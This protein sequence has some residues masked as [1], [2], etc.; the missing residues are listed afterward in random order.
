[1]PFAQFNWFL[2]IVTTQ[3]LVKEKENSTSETYFAPVDVKIRWHLIICFLATPH[4]WWFFSFLDNSQIV[5]HF[6]IYSIKYLFVFLFICTGRCRKH[7][8]QQY[9]FL[10]TWNHCSYPRID[11]LRRKITTNMANKICKIAIVKNKEID[12]TSRW[13]LIICLL[14]LGQAWKKMQL[15]MATM[16]LLFLINILHKA[17]HDKFGKDNEQGWLG[18]DIPVGVLWN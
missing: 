2:L 8:K 18:G 5:S 14:Q 9:L 10:A 11:I 16:K 13:Q 12:V 1:M 7:V 17:P 4:S 6:F 3:F 15:L